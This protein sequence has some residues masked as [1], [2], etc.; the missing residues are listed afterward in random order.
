M[1]A[2]LTLAERLDLTAARPLAGA[3]E[4]V[5]GDIRLDASGVRFLG[6]L[7]L[8]ILLAAR[9]QCRADQR[10]FA[11]TDPSEEFDEAL[12]TL[13]VDP[14]FLDGGSDA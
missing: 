9:Q 2:G 12:R 14:R 8:Q 11:I 4:A 5:K 6:G 13:G 10:G 1:T 7:C 3:I